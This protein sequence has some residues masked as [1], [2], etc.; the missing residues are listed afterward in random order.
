M[1]AS[2]PVFE[3]FPERPQALR[4]ARAILRHHGKS[5]YFSTCLFP[6]RLQEATW[7][8]YAFVRLP[9]E[10][11][12]TSPQETPEDVERIKEKIAQFCADWRHAYNSGQSHSRVLKLA[13]QTWHEYAIP[14]DYSTAFL[15]A[16]VLDTWKT[17]YKNYPDLEAYM[18]GSAAVIG[19]MMSHLV[20]FQGPQT[21]EHAKALGNAM[22]LTNFLRDIDEDFQ[23]RGRVYMPQDELARFGISR[24][25]IAARR[26]SNEF[27]DFMRFQVTRADSLYDFANQGIK[28]LEPEGRFA[29]AMAST[30]Y[31]AILRKLEQQD[32]NPFA[33]RASTSL[34]H[35]L[36]LMR[37][38]RALSRQC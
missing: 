2:S 12:D 30:L 31:R 11:V 35:K 14:F 21:L 19:L 22:Q 1:T 26:F 17:D 27:R 34:P 4:E 38:A 25:D 32:L 36:V 20:G 6:R 7:S 5:Y 37:D 15:D 29:V 18:Y 23:T 9:D 8:V 33:R 16:M 28:Q 3:P 10:I 13:S 24:D